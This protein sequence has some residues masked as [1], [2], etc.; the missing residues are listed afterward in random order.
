MIDGAVQGDPAV[1]EPL[2]ALDPEID[3]FAMV[4]AP[5]LVRLHQDPEEPMPYVGDTALIDELPAEAIQ[6]LIAVAGP[7][8]GS[9]LAMVEL[10][11]GGGALRRATPGHGAVAGVDGAVRPVRRRR[12]RSTPEMAAV[13]QAHA[14]A[15]RPRW[16]RGTR[17]RPL[18]QLRRGA[19]RHVATYVDTDT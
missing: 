15:S 4:P 19:G 18:P 1:L 5:A 8:S 7:G 3:T 11:Q 6:A 9:P 2:R 16:R 17:R 14:A 13:M 10:R 12:S